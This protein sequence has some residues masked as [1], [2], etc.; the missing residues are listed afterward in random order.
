MLEKIISVHNVTKFRSYDCHGDVALAEITLIY[1]ENARGKSTL[2]AI[3]RSLSDG[4]PTAIIAR[5][6]AD[7]DDDPEVHIRISGTNARFTDQAWDLQIPDLIIFD[8]HFVNSNI[9]SGDYVS[10]DH[11]LALYHIV[12]GEQGVDWAN[13]ITSL[14]Q[15]IRLLKGERDNLE[16]IIRA[17]INSTMRFDEFMDLHEPDNIDDLI[18]A[19]SS[20]ISAA[21]RAQE[22]EDHHPMS[23]INLPA[24]PYQEMIY[25]LQIDL[26]V[27]SQA[28]KDAVDH[29][30]S[31][32][33]DGAINWIHTGRL[34]VDENDLE[35]C[36][37][38]GQALDASILLE[39][40]EAYFHEEY[41]NLKARVDATI[42]EIDTLLG[43]NMLDEVTRI[44][45]GNR[46]LNEFW[47]QHTQYQ[48]PDYPTQQLSNIIRNLK[49]TA[50]SALRDKK[51]SLLDPLPPPE[52]LESAHHD[53]REL[54]TTLEGI[55]RILTGIN[56]KIDDL[57][58]ATDQ[59]DVDELQ[60]QLE[61]LA[62]TRVRFD[63]EVSDLC[64]QYAS[65]QEQ[66]EDSTSEK[67][68]IRSDLDEYSEETLAAYE[69]SIN[70]FLQMSTDIQ[71]VNVGTSHAGGRP[72][73]DFQL[74]V[75]GVTVPIG[76]DR[77]IDRASFTTTL[78][79]GDKNCLA[80]AF[81]LALL[82]VQ[83][84]LSDKI[85]VIDD[86]I[87]SLDANRRTT[88]Y[89]AI[90]DLSQRCGQLVVMSHDPH[91]LHEIS[92]R[93]PSPQ[94][95][96]IAQG[97]DGSE[98]VAWNIKETVRN[99]LVK[100][101]ELLKGYV[102]RSEG[103]PQHVALRIRPYLEGIL[104]IKYPDEFEANEWLGD[105]LRKI[106]ESDDGMAL[107]HLQANVYEELDAICD[108]SK[109]FHHDQNE[110][111]GNIRISEEEL[112]HFIGRT[113]SLKIHL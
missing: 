45:A 86:P 28:A 54:E 25:L 53:Y 92:T 57:K 51:A 104:R 56:E 60:G 17:H 11:R 102:E 85:I 91:F 18:N 16:R 71:I 99:T 103:Q 84:D 1:G 40:Y 113:L 31:G 67:A 68:S 50:L 29:H 8:S 47:Q 62:D 37:F 72:R 59:A 69:D 100:D 44:L 9:F 76:S 101:Y 63:P 48:F 111:A 24:F 46:T 49:D 97:E 38:C 35:A 65:I 90:V 88:T 75:N 73:T 34:F 74:S 107:F 43:E 78:S 3:L 112:R 66:I 64:D 108:Y 81:F 30:L 12:I 109:Q 22:I 98:I 10:S 23:Q 26:D 20:E 95:L 41:E 13:Q 82:D 15:E 87:T 70:H 7:L 61:I 42:R 33:P 106:R 58:V 110:N 94:H 93:V 80:F 27:I 14:D 32:L 36:P 105:F 5:K 2:A 55:N 4:D 77:V 21:T 6:T 52:A 39:H 83:D 96:H 79:D 19:K 89:Q